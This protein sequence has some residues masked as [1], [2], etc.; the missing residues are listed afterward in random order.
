MELWPYV[1]LSLCAAGKESTCKVGDL[2]SSSGLRTS[3]GEWEG[4]PLQYSGLENTIDCIVH[5]VAKSQT[6]PGDFHLTWPC[7]LSDPHA[8]SRWSLGTWKNSRISYFVAGLLSLF[9]VSVQSLSHVWLFVTPLAPEARPPYLLPTT[10]DHPNP[11]PL[12]QWCHPT[13]LSSVIPFSSFPQSFPELGSFQ[14]SQLF[15]VGGQSIGVSASASVLLMNIQD[16]LPFRWTGWIS[17]QSKGLSRVFSNTTVQKYQF[18]C[19]QPS[20]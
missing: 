14:M 7:V 16:W 1:W 10:E 15:T 18:F 6:W 13:I 19:T 8:S 12:S 11:C 2:G 17:L 9:S 3:P 5:G 20:L 4:Y